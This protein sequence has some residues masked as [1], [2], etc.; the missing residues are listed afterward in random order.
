MGEWYLRLGVCYLSVGLPVFQ[1]VSVKR[2]WT[3]LP[4]AFAA[5]R[6]ALGNSFSLAAGSAAFIIVVSLACSKMERKKQPKRDDEHRE[7]TNSGSGTHLPAVA[8]SRFTR[9]WRASRLGDLIPGCLR[10]FSVLLWLPFLV[11]VSCS[12]SV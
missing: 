9:N 10:S 1:L 7:E 5:G 4:E 8:V 11:P 6:M 12:A 3:E 2:T